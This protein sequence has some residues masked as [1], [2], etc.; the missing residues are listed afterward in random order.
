MVQLF[1]MIKL[2]G[3]G[4]RTIPYVILIAACVL[5]ILSGCHSSGSDPT[6]PSLERESDTLPDNTQIWGIF[7]ISIDLEAN[8]IEAVPS[9]NSQFTCNVT[10]FCEMPPHHLRFSNMHG[11]VQDDY[12]D[13]SVDI[14]IEHPFPGNDLYVGF[15][16]M[17]VYLGEAS[18]LYEG[19]QTLSVAT[20]EDPRMLNPDGYTRWFNAPE[21]EEAG[22][23]KPLFG[24]Y[25]AAQGTQGYTPNGTLNP[26][27][28]YC[29]A[30]HAADLE[31]P[32]RVLT[33]PYA[34]RGA[35]LPGSLNWRRYVIRRPLSTTV[36]F[37]YAIVAHWEPNR[38]HPDPPNGIEDF[39]ISANAA[40][41]VAMSVVDQSTLYYCDEDESGGWVQM[42]IS[43]WDWSSTWSGYIPEYSIKCFSDAWDGSFDVDMT[44]LQ[45][46]GKQVIYRA[47]IEVDS[48]PGPDPLTVWF[49]VVY[50]DLDY[51]NHLGIPNGA[52]GPLTAYFSSDARVY[53][54][55]PELEVISPNG[56]ERYQIST[57]RDITW[58]SSCFRDTVDIEYSKDDFVSDINI[59]ATGED[60]DGVYT[61]ENI[62]DDPTDTA[63]VRIKAST[64]PGVSDISDDYFT[65]TDSPCDPSVHFETEPNDS[66]DQATPLLW[67]YDPVTDDFEH[68]G[69]LCPSGDSDWYSIE[70][71]TDGSAGSFMIFCDDPEAPENLEFTVY[72]WALSPV[73]IGVIEE[74]EIAGSVDIGTVTETGTFYLEIHSEHDAIFEYDVHPLRCPAWNEGLTYYETERNDGND[75]A[76]PMPLDYDPDNDVNNFTGVHDAGDYVDVFR[77]DLEEP[78]RILVH[79]ADFDNASNELETL[80]LVDE[81]MNLI[82][83]DEI[84]YQDG[85][86]L[87]DSAGPLE[88]G[89]YYIWMGANTWTHRYV[90]EPLAIL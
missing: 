20:D 86:L 42:N 45:I 54:M 67:N 24:Y 51:S 36:R 70:I 26:Y 47:A 83:E 17:G 41:A 85:S 3:L 68:T 30:I 75:I 81:E 16:V 32:Y 15:D 1:I 44:P 62:P 53:I 50:P 71:L 29:D 72:N 56:G 84:R 60:D 4:A 12:V 23:K 11:D 49:E 28:Y 88:P 87:L 27:K 80:W 82:D 19:S 58:D 10:R 5:L 76:D 64:D 7:D 48:L 22:E 31:S 2:S 77:L 63:K 37:Q 59:I 89:S 14:G 40:E 43:P 46:N 78:A 57:G 69:Q 21:F 33:L 13:I 35:F 52:E 61:W 90:L 25:A 34:L 38:F 65:I 73:E 79:M 55:Q 74:G 39:P 9:R 18:G 8:T 66:H 6:V